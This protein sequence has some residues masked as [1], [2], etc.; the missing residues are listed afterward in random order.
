MNENSNAKDSLNNLKSNE[1]L[2][3]VYWREYYEKSRERVK[4]SRV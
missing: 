3:F 1:L 4:F 2:S